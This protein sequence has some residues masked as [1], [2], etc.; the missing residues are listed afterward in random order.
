MFGLVSHT[1]SENGE[2]I[3]V[4]EPNSTKIDRHIQYET[5]NSSR[6]IFKTVIHIYCKR[7]LVRNQNCSSYTFALETQASLQY[8]LKLVKFKCYKTKCYYKHHWC[9]TVKRLHS[10]YNTI[11][12]GKHFSST[13][14]NPSILKPNKKADCFYTKIIYLPTAII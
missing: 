7:V 10:I 5:P 11:H 3:A 2:A 8:Q 14:H 13:M 4:L 12:T 1:A 6:K 9:L